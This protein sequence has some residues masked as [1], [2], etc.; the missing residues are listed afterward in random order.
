MVV[1]VEYER[2]EG[3]F[4]FSQSQ[5]DELRLLFNQQFD[6]FNDDKSKPTLGGKRQ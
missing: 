6:L 1:K 2:G 5:I 4:V 3:G